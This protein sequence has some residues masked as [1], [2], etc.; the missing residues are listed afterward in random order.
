MKGGTA[1]IIRAIKDIF[2]E[3]LSIKALKVLCLLNHSALQILSPLVFYKS[4]ISIVLTLNCS[5]LS[6]QTFRIHF[7]LCH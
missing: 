2:F 4:A 5:T 7:I 6:Q 1:F 3:Y